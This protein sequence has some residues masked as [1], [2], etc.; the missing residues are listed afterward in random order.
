MNLGGLVLL[1]CGLFLS[2]GS[3]EAGLAA[4]RGTVILRVLGEI[5][6]TNQGDAALFDRDMIEALGME[7]LV[8]ETPW[9][10]GEVT[11]EGVQAKRL[12]EVLGDH[13]EHVL[14]RALND[15]TVEIPAAD[16]EA[17]DLFLALKMDGNYLRVRDKGPI[18]VIYPFSGRPEL[19]TPL[20]H[21][22]AIWQL[23]QLEFN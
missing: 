6:H 14:A 8:T 1:A 20:Y 10:E 3:A 17:R 2:A 7:T 22:R 21:N 19:N 23:E 11:F 16:L 5:E 13:G 9:T 18:W 4:P 12:L 15:Y